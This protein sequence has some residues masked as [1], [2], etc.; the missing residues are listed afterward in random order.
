MYN[1]FFS[2]SL[3]IIF[4]QYFWI[5]ARQLKD[6]CGI[7]YLFTND[8]YAME[9]LHK[10]GVTINPIERKLVQSN[11]TPPS[12]AF[13]DEIIIFST[14]YKAIEKK[15]K[16]EFKTKGWI[17]SG[18]GKNAGNE[19]IRH[20]NLDEIVAV[21]KSILSKYEFSSAEMCY[22]GKRYVNANNHIVEKKL[23]N[24]R[25]DFL[26]IRDGDKIKCDKIEQVFEVKNNGIL[27]NGEVLTLSAYIE[28]LLSKPGK[29]NKFNGYRYFSYKNKNL[30]ETW[31]S[32]TNCGNQSCI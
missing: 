5:M 31:Q 1:S 13:Y 6:C 28:T 2:V 32:L 22:Q 30:Y 8:L 11:S 21:Y 23:P 25:L 20:D 29:T 16:E 14:S 7:V 18:K 15:L 24:C 17:L 19:W 27:V 10:F 9:G 3:H 26:G 4:N 12:H